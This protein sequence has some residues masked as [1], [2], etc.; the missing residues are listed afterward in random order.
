MVTQPINLS[1]GHLKIVI[2]VLRKYLPASSNVFVFGSRTKQ[3]AKKFSDLDLAVDAG[4]PLSFDDLSI[5]NDAFIKSDFPYKVDIVDLHTVTDVFKQIIVE[6]AVE[7]NW[8]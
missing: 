1:N 8:H 6:Q 7:L 5:L 3:I 4:K 2:E